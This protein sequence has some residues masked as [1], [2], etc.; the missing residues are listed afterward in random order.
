MGVCSR[1]IWIRSLV[2]I[3]VAI[4]VLA[5]LIILPLYVFNTPSDLKLV[6]ELTRYGNRSSKVIFPL[7][8]NPDQNFAEPNKLQMSGAN[9]LYA[10]GGTL[11]E[12]II[13]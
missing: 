11:R 13:R 5:A 1:K 12:Y 8:S 6:I 7:A 4:I 3:A 2:I 10:T 9:R